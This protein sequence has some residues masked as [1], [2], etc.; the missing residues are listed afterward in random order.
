MELSIR[1]LVDWLPSSK[2]GEG[3]NK[4]ELLVSNFLMTTIK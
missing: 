2:D 4:E 1:V 3:G